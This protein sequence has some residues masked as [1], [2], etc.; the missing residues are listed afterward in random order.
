MDDVAAISFGAPPMNLLDT[1]H[2]G[3]NQKFTSLEEYFASEGKKEKVYI[4]VHEGTYYSHQLMIDGQDLVIEGQGQVNFYCKELYE[5]VMWII[6]T[7]IHVKNIHMKHFVPGT[8]EGQNCSGRVIGF[9]GAQNITIEKCDLNGCGLAGLHDNLG[10]SNILIKN[11][12][13]HNNSVGAFTNIDGAIWLEEID[14]HPVFHF[15]NNHM[16]NNGPDRSPET[17]NS[18]DYI[19][20]C[21]SVYETELIQ[22]VDALR[23]EWREVPNPLF[24]R[25]RGYEIGDYHHILFED[26]NGNNYDFGPG[27]NDFGELQ[28]LFEDYNFVYNP[29]DEDPLYRLFWRW[30]VSTFPCCSGE[31]ELVE[32][33]IPSVIQIELMEED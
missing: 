24:V 18:T 21:P 25:Y 15:E 12:F 4:L 20:S 13:I 5:N 31:Y 3:A 28:S 30:K 9:D 32:A 27:N 1:I 16:V 22:Y 19:I 6:G 8:M 14:D 23:E 2:I 10:N 29:E 33:Y 11:N 7:N 17:D 26:D